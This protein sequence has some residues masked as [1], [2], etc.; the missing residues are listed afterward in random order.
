MPLNLW[1]HQMQAVLRLELKKTFFARRGLWIYI[2]AFL[3]ALMF[4]AHSVSCMSFGESCNFGQDTDV[5]ATTFQLFYLR[6]A[7]FFGC[8][9][10]FM[11]LFRGEVLDK[12]LH[13]YFLAPIRR[14]VLLAGKFAAGLIASIVIFS[15]SVLVQ[16]ALLYA[17]FDRITMQDYL[18]RGNGLSHVA[19]YVGVTALACAG[20]GSV[21]L[22][23]GIL[24][25]NPIVPAAAALVWESANVFLPPL[26]Q[27]FSVIYY[28][29]SL[30]PIGV[31]P[32]VPPPFSMLIVNPDPISPVLAIGGLLAVT[33][34]VLWLA[35][36]RVR[37]M[38][39]NYAA[40]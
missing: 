14:E 20:Y 25:R 10:I 16:L 39:I 17:P 33:A 19:A 27:K 1:L 7:I 5:F 2:L 22:A 15:T 37:S 23:A 4:G 26:L 40:D 32:D 30:C 13:F 9:G 35:G 3:P 28:L 29:K 24:I 12:S 11:N 21:F 36:R 6:L 34:L 31:L 38:E 18:L 8:L